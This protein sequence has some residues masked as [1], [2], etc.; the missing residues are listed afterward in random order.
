MPFLTHACINLMELSS[1]S[2]VT[3]PGADLAHPVEAT[4]VELGPATADI[5]LLLLQSQSKPRRSP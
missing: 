5:F 1:L 4:G 2:A 3:E